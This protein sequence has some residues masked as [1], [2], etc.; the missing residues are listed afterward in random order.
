MDS[1]SINANA[2]ANIY[3]LIGIRLKTTHN[4]ITIDISKITALATTAD[5]F[6]WYLIHNPVVAGTFTYAD[7][8]V[9]SAVQV[10]IGD[11][12]GN[13]SVNTI[14]LNTTST[15]NFQSVILDGGYGSN[16]TSISE[17]VETTF[18]LGTDIDGVSDTVVL[19]IRPLTANLN[20][21]G[22]M[23]WIQS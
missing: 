2:I 18:T 11:V 5:H 22:S 9:N 23:A 7:L 8:D 12:V 19:C 17:P 21:H 20:I 14:T 16:D 10:A 15:S 4:H 3:A 6:E 1:T 13:P